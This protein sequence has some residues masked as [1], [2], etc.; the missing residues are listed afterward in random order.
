MKLESQIFNSVFQMES[1]LEND[2]N[3]FTSYKDKFEENQ[4]F[5][6]KNETLKYQNKLW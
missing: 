3:Q 6:C 2:L 4:R 1:H 5:T